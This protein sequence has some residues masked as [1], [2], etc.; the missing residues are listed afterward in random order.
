MKSTVYKGVTMEQHKAERASRTLGDTIFKG[1]GKKEKVIFAEVG[2]LNHFFI[3]VP[4]CRYVFLRIRDGEAQV[5][6]MNSGHGGIRS[7]STGGIDRGIE[8]RS[9]DKPTSIVIP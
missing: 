4:P 3:A 9:Q 8:D 1:L 7:T 5:N 6:T 2:D